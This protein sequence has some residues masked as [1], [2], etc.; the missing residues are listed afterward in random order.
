MHFGVVESFVRIRI[1]T[2]VAR[3]ALFAHCVVSVQTLTQKEGEDVQLLLLPVCTLFEFLLLLFLLPTA[4]NF[5]S[6]SVYIV[7]DEIPLHELRLRLI[8]NGEK[9][10][11]ATEAEKEKI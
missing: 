3:V 10:V 11:R 5:V 8:K 1:S 9:F 2:S 4:L 7:D 6:S